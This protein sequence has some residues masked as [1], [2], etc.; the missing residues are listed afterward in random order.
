MLKTKWRLGAAVAGSVFI[1]SGCGAVAGDEGDSAASE[2][3]EHT[4]AEQQAPGGE[5]GQPE[6]QEPDLDNVPDIVAEV[7]G[8]EIIKDDF[9]AIYEGQ[10]QQMSMQAQMSGQEIDQDQLKNMTAEGLIGNE[11]LAQEAADRGIQASA[12]DAE[13]KLAELAETNQMSPDEF[14]AANE[15]QGMDEAAV[16]DELTSQILIEGLV[17]DE[18]GQFEAN[19]DEIQAAYQEVEDQQQMSGQ[20]GQTAALPPLDEVRSELEEQVISQKQAESIQTLADD[21]RE[22]ADVTIHL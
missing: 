5:A 13:Q 15:Q 17:E 6:M 21:L 20:A 2:Q 8:T 11:L 14:I 16:M 22:D 19:E 18:F 10:F 4:A 9:A 3:Q 7:N 12:K 1:L